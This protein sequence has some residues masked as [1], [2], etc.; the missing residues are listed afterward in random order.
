MDTE[1]IAMS[2]FVYSKYFNEL[3]DEAAKK[4]YEEKMKIVHHSKDPFCEL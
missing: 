3:K 1:W 2:V 4:R